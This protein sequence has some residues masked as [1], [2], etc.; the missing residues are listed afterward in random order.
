MLLDFPVQAT[1]E[2]LLVK[3]KK[4]LR[5]HMAWLL[6]SVFVCVGGGVGRAAQRHREAEQVGD[7]RF[8]T[9]E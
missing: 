7:P 1:W 6:G 5:G 2:P 9:P 8:L 3:D 4:F